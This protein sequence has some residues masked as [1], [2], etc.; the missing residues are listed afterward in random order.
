M[1]ILLIL[2]MTCAVASAQLPAGYKF[3]A[4]PTNT[5]MNALGVIGG[6]GSTDLSF[7]NLYCTIV[8]AS[9][10][11]E[12]V[13]ADNLAWTTNRLPAAATNGW[14]TGSHA[15]LA[16]TGSLG[17]AA[18]SNA[19]AFASSNQ[20]ALADTAMQTNESRQVQFSGLIRIGSGASGSYLDP[21]L[22]VWSTGYSTS[23]NG[24][25]IDLRYAN[26]A[27]SWTLNNLPI[28]TTTGS[29]SNLTDITYLQVGA[30]PTVH[31]HDAAAVTNLQA[32]VL[33]YGTLTNPAAFATSGQGAKADN[34]VQLGK[35]NVTT[36]S[37]MLRS[38]IGPS[39]TLYSDLDLADASPALRFNRWGTAKDLT[40]TG[41]KLQWD[42]SDIW[43]TSTLTNAAQI[44]GLTSLLG[45]MT[46]LVLNTNAPSGTTFA[47]GTLNLGT[48]ASSVAGV[49][50]NNQTGVT[51][52]GTFNGNGAGLTNIP[53]TGLSVLPLTNNEGR[54]VSLS[55]TL[56][57]AGYTA[58]STGIKITGSADTGQVVIVSAA[59]Q[60]ANDPF[61]IWSSGMAT[62]LLGFNAGNLT[63]TGNMTNT[64][65]AVNG[66]LNVTN[67]LT[68]GILINSGITNLNA[69]YYPVSD[70]GGA[71]TNTLDP[72]NGLEQSILCTNATFITSVALSA[73]N[74]ATLYLFVDPTVSNYAVTWD[75]NV[76]NVGTAGW[77]VIGTNGADL[78][79]RKCFGSTMWTVNGPTTDLTLG[80]NLTVS[81]VVLSTYRW[82]DAPM[83]FDYKTGGVGSPSLAALP[84]PFDGIKVLSF[85][86]TEGAYFSAQVNHNL[87]PSNATGYVEPHIHVM[88]TVAPTPSANRKKFTIVY[89]GAS[90]G[91]QLYGPI[92][93]VQDNVVIGT[94][95]HTLVDFGH[96]MFT[97]FYPNIS[98]KFWGSIIVDASTSSNYT[99]GKISFDGDFHYPVDRI[100]SAS[101]TAP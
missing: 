42:G 59:T 81:N 60:T 20:G 85:A 44:G 75:T 88:P 31:D 36:A 58:H 27:G 15:G 67:T 91:G 41:T 97:N 34:S 83:V 8:A 95:T 62:K 98:G 70:R 19:S 46:N 3:L 69:V 24:N 56:T 72:A 23:P 43:N 4:V 48:N 30:A 51:L 29:G 99:A 2:L 37:F 10:L 71:T 38:V 82:V 40:F 64:G 74:G 5:D 32:T 47:N 89:G 26:M 45:A 13:P 94:N 11:F 68:A 33:G 92:T 84:A 6:G 61:S 93:N 55:N 80:G 73:S 96:L 90:I 50:T 65:G 77:P 87:A 86:D 79:L 17:S 18:F 78:V 22:S 53:L 35:T 28:L 100:G 39:L 52:T 12:S 25:Y 21:S 54:A 1:K 7:T 57:V 9:N 16:A 76:F 14:E 63:I 49:V 66:S 101:D